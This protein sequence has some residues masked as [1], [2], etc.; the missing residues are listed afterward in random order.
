MLIELLA[1]AVLFKDPQFTVRVTQDIVYT[2]AKVG[3]PSRSEKPLLLDLYEP[4]GAAH[5]RPAVIT[6]HGGAFKRGDKSSGESLVD[7]CR[8]IASRGY[9]CASI[10]YRL[11]GDDPATRGVTLHDRAVAAAVE[12]TRAAV[13]W[14]KRTAAAH[15]VDR[16]RIVV[17]GRSAGAGAALRLAYSRAGRKVGIRAVVSMS[18]GVEGE[19]LDIRAG[20]APLCIIHG[21]N[22]T[23]VPVAGAQALA[24]RARAMSVPVELYLLEGRGN[25]HIRTFNREIDGETL[26]TKTLTFLYKY[27]DLEAGSGKREARHTTIGSR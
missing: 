16:R 4:E 27:L 13:A 3:A 20:D 15:R 17:A 18:G 26:L 19:Q 24:A 6:M 2:T 12:D 1:S 11:E 25:G 5:L 14:M 9:V 8:D 7:F 21:T 10:N 23:L 22:D